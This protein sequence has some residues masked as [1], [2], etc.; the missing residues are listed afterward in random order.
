[1]TGTFTLNRLFRMSIR[2]MEDGLYS[3]AAMDGTGWKVEPDELVSFLFF[4]N[5][6]ALYGLNAATDAEVAYLHADQLLQVFSVVHPYVTFEGL[7]AADD[8]QLT[9]IRQAAKAWTDPDLWNYA[10]VDGT[11]I[12]FDS[13]KAGISEKAAAVI[14]HAV[15]S[16]LSASAINPELLPSLLPHL[17]TYG[18]PGESVST[19]P[20]NVAFRLTEPEVSTDTEWLLESVIVG[21]RGA[22]WTPSMRKANAP[23]AEAL[24][25]KWKPYADEIVKKQSEMTSFIGSVEFVSDERFLSTPMSDPEVRTFIQNDLPLLQS[26]G[27]PVILPAWLKSVTES[28]LRIRTNAGVQSYKSATGLD[29]VLSF[30]WNFSLAGNAIDRDAFRKLVDENREYI[31]SGDEWFHIDPLW[32]RK[33]RDLMDRADA[34]EWTVKDLLF[35]DVPEELVPLEED[36]ENDDPL[37]AFSMQQSLR[38][39]M[40][41]LS[42][43]KGLPS[44]GIS[45]NLLAELR[46]YQENGY[47]WLIFMRDN[48][49]G[50]CLADDMGLGK[51]IQLITYLL[52]VHARTDTDSPSLIV[53]PTSVLGNWQKE[54]ER[55][56]P[57]L[58]IHTHYGPTRAKDENF[59]EL[60][61][62]LQPD[63]VLTTYGTASQDG[64]MLAE[65]EFASITLDE[66]Q[67]I[68]NMQT[69]QSRVI[70][71]LRG[72]H[73]IALTGT[74]I[75]NRLSELWA[76]FDFIHKGYF[77]S[78]RKFTDNYIIPIE[79]DDSEADKRKLRAKIRP[80][81]LRRTKSDPD[82]QLN[83]P[84][85]LE[86]NEYCPLTT[87]QAA[88]YESFLEE[89]KFKLQTLTGFEKKGLILKMLSR[90]KQLCNHPALFLK[91]PNAPAEQM[92]SRSNKLDLIVSMA[93]EIASNKEQCLIFT[94]YI[95]MGQLIRQCLSELHGIDVPFLTGS[96][97][98]GQRDRLVEAFQEGEFPIF[99]LSL[100]AGGTGLNLTGANHVLH[101]D[102]WWNP[103]VENQATDRAYRIGQTK[104][105]H[106]HKFVTLGTIEEKIDKM[107]VEKAAL[108]A[109]LIQS[110]QWLSDLSDTELEDL[111]SFDLQ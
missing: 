92:L 58:T 27:Y 3:I 13:N 83:L 62:Q 10:E 111:L 9:S 87:E 42:D 26:F 2:L 65:T 1:M 11:S 94:Q 77:G 90:L 66:A 57:S 22:H 38:S 51:T 48:S 82:L 61:Q 101:A 71:K 18:W 55:F 32:L 93:A 99:I 43:K 47:N 68:K 21:E 23:V 103:A 12:R 36:E 31:R 19:I 37:F 107:L 110:S 20:I 106:V 64:E 67:N 72:K 39:Y 16:K 56:A 79:R 28:K 105:V 7:T 59:K 85:K 78:F 80:F 108:S 69:K 63:V 91:E 86:Q 45:K 74:P 81:L 76:I 40:D 97:P 46:P 50:A 84:K 24:P 4:N 95:G 29:E 88:L 6:R 17:R 75:E 33:I 41:M 54:I 8:S 34:G 5:E 73:H 53:C 52:N 15:S 44:A 100:K 49:F 70:R 102:R 14:S 60:I 98:K 96:M 109:D 35:Q 30:D 89:T 25:A 104:F